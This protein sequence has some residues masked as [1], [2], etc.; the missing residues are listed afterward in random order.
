M[1][2]PTVFCAPCNTELPLN[3][4]TSDH[5]NRA[6]GMTIVSTDR[7]GFFIGSPRA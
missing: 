2:D 5:A 3:W 4:E 6:H 7:D 1:S